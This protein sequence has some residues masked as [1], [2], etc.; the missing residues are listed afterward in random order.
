MDN[1]VC[2]EDVQSSTYFDCWFYGWMTG[3][4][5]DYVHDWLSV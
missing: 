4:V 3:Y 5:E 2:T 1:M